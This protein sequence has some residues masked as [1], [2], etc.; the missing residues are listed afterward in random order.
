MTTPEILAWATAIASTGQGSES[1]GTAISNTMSDIETAVSSGGDKLQAFADVAGMSAEEF[2][3]AWN[4]TPSDAMQ[5][6]IEGLKRINEEGGSVDGTLQNL[7]IT[8]V[9]QKQALQGLTQTCDTLN[10]SLTM[11]EDAWN[12]VGDEW[13]E[14]GDAA[15]EAGQKSEGFSG[16]L[17]ILKNSANELGYEFG[18]ALIPFMQI[19]TVAIQE[20][21]DM[22]ADAPTPIKN[23]IVVLG[24]LGVASGPVITAYSSLS[25]IFQEH[26]K[27][28]AAAAAAQKTMAA[29][30]ATATTSATAA[31][32]AFSKANIQAK[33]MA[34]GTKA[35]AVAMNALK[36]AAGVGALVALQLLLK[37]LVML[38]PMRR[39]LK[40]Q[41]LLNTAVRSINTA[42]AQTSLDELSGSADS[43]ALSLEDLIAKQAE[44]ADT[45]TQRNQEV[46]NSQGMLEG[47]R[48]VINQLAG[49]SDLATED[50]ALCK[51]RL[52]AL[53]TYAVAITK[54]FKTLLALGSS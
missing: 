26:K 45:I 14:A 1:A 42:Q 15:R 51:R 10:D 52:M 24:L 36:V 35:A 5:A 38:I 43:T 48:D 34:V 50:V 31:S 21:T 22:F 27:N 3:T 12:G 11:S 8:G 17:Q 44:L 53:M 16:T 4:E 33:A 49:S 23:L 18:Q 9:R 25:N 41:P 39:T 32:G 29:S 54:L 46:V 20:L 47:Y 37:L 6:F 30:T 13:G 28:A 2:A 7:G 40:R 19:A